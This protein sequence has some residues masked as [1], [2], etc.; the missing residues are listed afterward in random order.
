MGAFSNFVVGHSDYVRTD[1]LIFRFVFDGQN[2]ISRLYLFL[3]MLVQ[4]VLEKI[5]FL[6]R[7]MSCQQ[8]IVGFC[9]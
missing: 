6:K 2:P 4:I 3:Q 1:N 8:E 9:C 5:R 7:Y